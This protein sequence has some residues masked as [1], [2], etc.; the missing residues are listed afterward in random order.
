LLEVFILVISS[1]TNILVV[2][3]H[4]YVTLC[5]KYTKNILYC[6]IINYKNTKMDL[7]INEEFKKLIPPLSQE[8][9][10]QLED[11]CFN[12]GIREKILTW[13]GFIIDG[14][15]RYE[16]ASN[17]GLEYKTQEKHFNNESEVKEWMILNQF[18]RRNLNKYQ[19]STLALKLEN[20]F[21]EKAKE[22]LSKAGASYSPKEGRHNCDKVAAAVDTKK[23]LA[24]VANVSHNT[25]S[26]VKKIEEKA[27]PE[28]KEQLEKGEVSINQ[29]YKEVKKVEKKKERKEV[30]QKQVDDIESGKL[31]EL[32]GKYSVISI[33]PPWNYGREYD[34]NGSRVANPYPEM[35][36]EQ[37]QEIDLPLLDD[38]VLC[39]WTTHA[40]LPIAFKLLEAWGMEYKATMVWDKENIGMGAWFRM[41][42]EFCLVAVKGK[43][44]WDNT[45]YRDIL[46]SKR[47]EHS[48]KPDEFFDMIQEITEGRRL[49]YFSREKREGWDVFGNDVEKF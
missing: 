2:F 39:L 31:P 30:I 8:E 6:G 18:G 21:Q 29:A 20:V 25:I 49:E 9:F 10:K 43:P 23:E 26:R 14:H 35:T 3:A 44:F 40:F 45:K 42:C 33:D 32:K 47:R 16:I 15:N 17:W 46:R 24:K 48:R 41:Q 4:N 12:E 13:R 19:R 5:H 38:S 27:S 28:L 11:N 37:I 34:P 7:K 1:K 36:N 22:N